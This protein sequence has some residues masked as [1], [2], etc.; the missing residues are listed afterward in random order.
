MAIF[1]FVS[2]FLSVDKSVKHRSLTQE[3]AL[4]VD[5]DRQNKAPR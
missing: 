4:A 3:S 1:V 2:F 5:S